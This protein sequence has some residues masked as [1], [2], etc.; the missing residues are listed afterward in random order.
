[1]S[2]H[3]R[4][5][6]ATPE[7]EPESERQEHYCRRDM[8][9]VSSCSGACVHVTVITA[10]FLEDSAAGGASRHLQRRIKPANKHAKGAMRYAALDADSKRET[11]DDE[12]PSYR[13]QSPE[14][15]RSS[16]ATCQD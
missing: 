14:P 6:S 16:D 12:Q 4:T 15:Y 8:P 3:A 7:P 13:I 1:M 11:N 10:S 2:R 5:A 9:A